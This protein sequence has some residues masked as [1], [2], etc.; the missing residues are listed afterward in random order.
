[1]DLESRQTEVDAEIADA[2]LLGDDV[3][4][5]RLKAEMRKTVSG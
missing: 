3:K 4:K 5:P 1:M 2:N